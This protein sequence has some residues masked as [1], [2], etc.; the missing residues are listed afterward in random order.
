[1]NISN[2]PNAA[3][4]MAGLPRQAVL[5]RDG[6]HAPV[7]T[8]IAHAQKFSET[9]ASIESDTKS[10]NGAVSDKV[11]IDRKKKGS[12]TDDGGLTVPAVQAN[13]NGLPIALAEIPI[14]SANIAEGRTAAPHTVVAGS[15]S[16]AS[17]STSTAVDAAAGAEVKTQI[18]NALR[19]ESKPE[20]A[21]ATNIVPSDADPTGPT[22][23]FSNETTPSPAGVRANGVDIVS[24]PANIAHTSTI[25][26]SPVS[27]DLHTLADAFET[28]VRHFER[29]G[30]WVG[31]ASFTL[32]SSALK[33]ASFQLV[34]DGSSLRIQLAQMASASMPISR[35][36]ESRLGDIL[37]RKLGRDVSLD[38]GSF[39]IEAAENAEQTEQ[40]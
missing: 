25:S 3:S 26:P 8:P 24:K 36:E 1:M 9:I 38:L 31:R 40:Q 10:G 39:D 5:P 16:I 19:G 23:E 7:S 4:A 34:S 17:T 32:Q 35:R 29:S 2:T 18:S 21:A 14:A 20:T 13:I 30:A 37:T 6:A 33:G 11:D 27:S 15:I 22:S 28:S 12:K